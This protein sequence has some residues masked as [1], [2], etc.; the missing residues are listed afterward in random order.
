M[1][2]QILMCMTRDS[3]P[4]GLSAK[5]FA[6]IPGG[7]KLAARGHPAEVDPVG[8]IRAMMLAAMHNVLGVSDPIVSAVNELKT[9]GLTSH[10]TLLTGYAFVAFVRER[11]GEEVVEAMVEELPGLGRLREPAEAVG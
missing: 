10:Q 5:I 11:A 2:A 7:E 8:G 3:F 1:I 4:P 9:V 6:A